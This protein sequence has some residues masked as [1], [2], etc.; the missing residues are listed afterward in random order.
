MAAPIETRPPDRSPEALERLIGQVL[1]EQPL[2]SAPRALQLSV[3]AEIERREALPWWHHSFLHWPLAIRA[4]FVVASLGV[5]KLALT[6][7]MLLVARLHSEPVV[8]V[9]TKP[10]SWA[11]NSA[12]AVSKIVSVA[13]VV[14]NAIPPHWLYAGIA[15][16]ATLY[17][18]LVA[19][20]ATAYRTLYAGK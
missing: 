19:L 14:L 8:A 15:L 17:L 10:M 3:L 20:G 1:K 6:G 4:L 18:A 11:E 9:I 13:S 12:A 7:V 5:A 16:A 2:R